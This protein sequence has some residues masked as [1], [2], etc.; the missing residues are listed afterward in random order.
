MFFFLIN[1]RFT[2]LPIIFSAIYLILI[3]FLYCILKLT[4]VDWA[5]HS[6]HRIS[7]YTEKWSLSIAEVILYSNFDN[8]NWQIYTVLEYVICWLNGDGLLMYCYLEFTVRCELIGT[9]AI[10]ARKCNIIFVFFFI[11][12]LSYINK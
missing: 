6:K 10:V 12:V 9:L 4:Q 1:N 5:W 8:F 3:F 7:Y 11:L 2:L